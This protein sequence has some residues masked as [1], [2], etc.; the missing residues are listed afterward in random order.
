MVTSDLTSLQS[1]EARAFKLGLLSALGAYLMWGVVPAY[2]KLTADVPAMIVICYRIL[3]SVLFVGGYLALAG[4]LDQLRDVVAS[5]K[6]FGFVVLASVLVTTNWLVFIYSVEADRVLDASLGYFINPLISVALGVV[7]LKERLSR[8]QLFALVL[9]AAAVLYQT[10]QLG[11]F[12]WISL[13]LAFSFALYG[14]VRKRTPVG[15]ISGQL[16]E[17]LIASPLAIFG[18][19][20]FAGQGL[21]VVPAQDPW[22]LVALVGTGLV[23]AAPLTLFA[24][25]A[26]RLPLTYIGFLQ[27]VAPSMQF[28]FAVWVWNEPLSTERLTGFVVIWIA[29]AIFTVDSVRGHRK[30]KRNQ[31]G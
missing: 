26:R 14:L 8:G 25:G 27:Y 11:V 22:L 10:L 16:G 7:F 12:P 9:S 4:R 30:R 18:L 29:L 19:F 2:Y 31:A 1:E 20:Y 21:T 23:T 17:V 28:M 3:G 13:T 15:A 24:F 6:V 5:R